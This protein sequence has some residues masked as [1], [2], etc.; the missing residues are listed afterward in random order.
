MRRI[1]A[2]GLMGLSLLGAKELFTIDKIAEY[3]GEDNAF[4]Y[5]TKA[6]EYIYKQK[7]NFFLGDFDTKVSAKYEKKEYPLSEADFFDMTIEKP[8]EN[9]V[10]F[11]AGFRDAQGT[12]EYNNIKTGYEGEARVGIKVDMFSLFNNMSLRKFNLKTA[13]LESKKYR[14]VSE[15]NLR[16]LYFK[17]L[18]N[19]HKL[20]YTQGVLA[21][22]SDLLLTAQERDQI[23]KQKVKLG[24][25]AEITLLEA[26][27][28]VINREQ[29]LLL[30]QNDFANAMVNFLQ[31][32]NITQEDFMDNFELPRIQS[33]PQISMK[34]E[35]ALAQAL[36]NRPDLKVVD[37]EI[38]KIDLNQKQTE[39]LKYPNINLSLYGVHDYEYENGFKVSL[40]MNFPI[41]RRKY[42]GKYA[43]NIKRLKSLENDK[44]RRVIAIKTNL[45]KIFNTLKNLEIN[46]KNSQSEVIL[47]EKLEDA[48]H[49][50]YTH[51]LSHLFVVN[52]REVYTLEVKK[53]LL[54][55]YLK[56]F[57]LQQEAKREIG[58]V[59][60][61]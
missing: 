1:V 17:I 9:G 46:I 60:R 58:L 33:V 21:L 3:L 2:L 41:E 44:Q 13:E 7:I 55:Y 38:D 14:F 35:D 37:Y 47:V 5:A 32:L 48:E 26:D 25:L 24:A 12:Q 30:A 61:L 49:K 56:Y 36:E 39:L 27:Q 6:Q 8:L 10:E 50:R 15:N 43:E 34:L 20:L 23:I 40:G 45:K 57:L 51:G 28:Q 54:K 4:M 19:Y 31:Y 18:S 16:E 42:E 52:Q 11:M 53:K 22:E 29:R 59:D